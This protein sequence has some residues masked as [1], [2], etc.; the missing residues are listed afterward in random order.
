M[1]VP[2]IL[3]YENYTPPNGTVN[4]HSKEHHKVKCICIHATLIG[5]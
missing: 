4:L 2:E 3:L 5:N 1:H